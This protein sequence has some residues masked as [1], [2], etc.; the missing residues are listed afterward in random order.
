M[1]NSLLTLWPQL[2]TAWVLLFH[3]GGVRPVGGKNQA[4]IDL[5]EML[6]VSNQ[7]G[8]GSQLSLRK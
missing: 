6:F 5:W 4:L 2:A 1:H 8:E 3:H 7:Q